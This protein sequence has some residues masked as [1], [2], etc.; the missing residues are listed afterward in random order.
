MFELV[1]GKKT[2][3]NGNEYYIVKDSKGICIYTWDKN[4]VDKSFIQVSGDEYT[5]YQTMYK[6]YVNKDQI[7]N[8]YNFTKKYEYK[9]FKVNCYNRSYKGDYWIGTDDKEVA[10]VIGYDELYHDK[11]G[12][13]VYFKQVNADDK[14]LVLLG[15]DRQVTYL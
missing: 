13:V 10:E 12:E 1:D 11:Y 2:I 8:I 3:F 15:E 4:I 14:D 9:G 6:K 7:G 5:G